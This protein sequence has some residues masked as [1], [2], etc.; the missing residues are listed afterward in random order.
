M[1]HGLLGSTGFTGKLFLGLALL[2]ENGLYRLARALC[3]N[4]K[5]RLGRP[6]AL[7]LGVVMSTRPQHA[8]LTRHDATYCL[9]FRFDVT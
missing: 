3:G 2:Y 6:S 9:C 1:T 7:R 5:C 4:T 8:Y